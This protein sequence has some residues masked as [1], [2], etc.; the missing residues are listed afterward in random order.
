MTSNIIKCHHNRFLPGSIGLF[1]LEFSNCRRGRRGTRWWWKWR[2]HTVCPA[3]S[4]TARCNLN[5]L[6]FDYW[7]ETTTSTDGWLRTSQRCK[8]AWLRGC[9]H[10]WQRIIEL[11]PL[12]LSGGWFARNCGRRFGRRWCSSCLCLTLCA[13]QRYTRTSFGGCRRRLS[14]TPSS[15]R[16]LLSITRSGS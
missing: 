10:C 7:D 14:S 8:T 3:H 13:S 4:S 1:V 9:C 2:S 5:R 11:C 6:F 16:C 12:L 15:T